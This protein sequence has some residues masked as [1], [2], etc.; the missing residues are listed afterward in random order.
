[1]LAHAGPRRARLLVVTIPEE[2]TTGVIIA[3][4]REEAP[5]PPIIVRAATAAGVERLASLDLVGLVG[6][7]DQLKAAQKVLAGAGE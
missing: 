4:A 1:V 6:D 5:D 7:E 2:A 3:A